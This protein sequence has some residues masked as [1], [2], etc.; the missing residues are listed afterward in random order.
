MTVPLPWEVQSR[1]ALIYLPEQIIWYLLVVLAPAG[2][3]LAMRRNPLVASLLVAHAVI[4]AMTVAL[5][6]GNVGTLVR[7]RGLALPYFLWLS[8]VALCEIVAHMPARGRR[9]AMAPAA[10]LLVMKKE[11]LCR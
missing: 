5:T 7:H 3:V 1:S 2:V 10:A 6:G 4:A 11:L 9:G 8:A